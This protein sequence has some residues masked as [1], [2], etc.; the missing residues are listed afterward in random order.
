MN[1]PL[2][3]KNCMEDFVFSH[4]DEIISRDN[5]ICRCDRCR[6]DIALLALNRLKPYYVSTEK[7]DT[8]TR[9]ALYEKNSEVDILCALAYA[10]SIVSVNP[11]HDQ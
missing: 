4:L 5:T 10:I 8:Y 1:K 9:L 2:K 3:I 11:N 6:T 7:G